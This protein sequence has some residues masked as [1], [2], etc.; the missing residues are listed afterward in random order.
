M[1]KQRW[2]KKSKKS[3]YALDLRIRDARVYANADWLCGEISYYGEKEL[4][5][6]LRAYGMNK[7]CHVE[8]G[9]PKTE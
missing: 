6:I 9:V 5:L 4:S 8:V 7:T 1:G 2:S 3:S